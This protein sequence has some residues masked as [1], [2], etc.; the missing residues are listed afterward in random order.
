MSTQD[1]QLSLREHASHVEEQS[2][3]G[4][5]PRSGF[6]ADYMEY[7]RYQESPTSF[8]FWVAATVISAVLRRN[9]WVNKGAYLVYPNLF[10]ILIAPTGKC[11]KSTA[12]NMGTNLLS[13]LPW[14][15]VLADKTTPEGLL[16]ALAYGAGNVGGKKQEASQ[17]PDSCGLIKASE[18]AVFLNKATYNQDMITILT[19]LYD[20]L[21]EFVFTTRTKGILQLH[22]IAVS[23]LGA[24]TADWLA[25]ALPKDAFGGGFMSRFIF[26]VKEETDRKITMVNYRLEDKAKLLKSKLSL[27]AKETTGPIK[28]TK[29]AHDWYVDWYHSSK[30]E[31]LE[32]ENL[33]GF[34]ERKQDLIL[35][36]AMILT[37]GQYFNIIDLTTIKQAYDIVTWTQLRSF[38]AFKFV[39]L[40]ALGGLK[41]KIVGYIKDQGGNV[42]RGDVTKRFSRQLPNG[43]RDIE[44]IEALFND[45]GEV[46]IKSESVN[47]RATK[48]YVL[49]KET[50]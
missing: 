7:T 29:A 20:C 12:L 14:V 22:N 23:M 39:G 34:V 43:I 31:P 37:A 48:R 36:L 26:V 42:R 27:I 17:L 5:L 32:D 28:L 3:E 18:L 1:R 30:D 41:E 47:G 11:R 13:G 45:T 4:L 40:T 50:K 35:K 24:S 6:F 15:N 9:A 16:E 25:S 21:P 2:F 10:T 19:S 46:D 33:T 44:A 49:V 38:E 8:H